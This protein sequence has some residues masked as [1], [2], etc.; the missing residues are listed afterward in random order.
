M[1]NMRFLIIGKAILLTICVLSLMPST[2]TAQERVRYI[3]TKYIDADGVV[4]KAGNEP[5]YFTFNGNMITYTS[6]NM[7]FPYQYHHT[8]NN[9][10]VYY[11]VTTDMVNGKR[12]INENSQLLVSSDKN[13]IN[14]LHFYNGQIHLRSVFKKQTKM[15]IGGIYE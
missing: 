10:T 13:T 5:A 2:A 15:E 7:S 8:E 11:Q 6:N 9:C 14:S 1:K 12:Y 4:S 3:L